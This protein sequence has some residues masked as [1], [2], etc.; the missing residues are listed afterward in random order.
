MLQQ[1]VM[2]AGMGN[3]TLSMQI[4][5]ELPQ[6]MCHAVFRHINMPCVLHVNCVVQQMQQ[7]HVR[8]NIS[9]SL[10]SLG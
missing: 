6:E 9:G 7:K 1:L 5:C 2:P 8:C 10:A 4:V 3:R